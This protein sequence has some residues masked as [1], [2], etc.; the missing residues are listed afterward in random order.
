M[1]DDLAGLQEDSSKPGIGFSSASFLS[2]S[3]LEKYLTYHPTVARAFPSALLLTSNLP[4][5]S[6]S[7]SPFDRLPLLSS[8]TI[9]RR[10]FQSQQLIA[11]HAHSNCWTQLSCF[12]HSRPAQVRSNSLALCQLLKKHIP[13]PLDHMFMSALVC[14]FLHILLRPL[15]FELGSN[16]WFQN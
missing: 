15:Q 3:W 9:Y 16:T 1:I 10:K 12:M 11:S 5:G 6:H 4:R 2:R 8:C 7:H 13:L 14:V